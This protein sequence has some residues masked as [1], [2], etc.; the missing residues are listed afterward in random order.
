MRWVARWA[1]ITALVAFLLLI[2]VFVFVDNPK[3]TFHY[4]KPWGRCNFWII[5][6]YTMAPVTPIYFL[7]DR[8][9]TRGNRRVGILTDDWPYCYDP[10]GSVFVIARG[11][12]TDFASIPNFARFYINPTSDYVMEAAIVHDWLYAVGKEG[13][14]QGRLYADDVFRFV[15]KESGVNFVRRNIMHRAV[16]M[17]GGNAYGRANELRIREISGLN[18]ER[19]SGEVRRS[20]EPYLVASSPLVDVT[21]IKFDRVVEIIPECDGFYQKYFSEYTRLRRVEN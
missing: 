4:Y 21:N 6:N 9:P 19:R 20:I 12:D 8:D 16:R 11:F 14:Q 17:G 3:R 10:D 1:N 18:E 7:V 2:C 13:D 15:L 5:C